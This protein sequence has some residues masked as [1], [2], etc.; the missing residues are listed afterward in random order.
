MAIRPTMLM[1]NGAEQWSNS[2]GV[3]TC[4][5][6]NVLCWRLS[7]AVRAAM[8]ASAGDAIDR[9]LALLA[10]LQKQGFG[11]IYLGEPSHTS[12]VKEDRL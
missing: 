10:E 4:A 9:G 3:L 6:D 11:V 12:G 7:D 2:H 1:A 8:Q 5:T